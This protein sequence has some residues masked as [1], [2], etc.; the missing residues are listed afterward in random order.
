MLG[1]QATFTESSTASPASRLGDQKSHNQCKTRGLIP[2][3]HFETET[4]CHR[5][6]IAAYAKGLCTIYWRLNSYT[7]EEELISGLPFSCWCFVFR[8]FILN[9]TVLDKHVL[10]SCHHRVIWK[11]AWLIFLLLV[12]YIMSS[13][14]SLS[15]CKYRKHYVI[16]HTHT[17]THTHGEERGH[18][19]P[20]ED[21]ESL[22]WMTPELVSLSS[23]LDLSQA[24]FKSY[25]T[26]LCFQHWI[27]HCILD[28]IELL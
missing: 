18:I 19:P 14:R 7:K 15:Y 3:W 1:S 21:A 16:S 10:S 6:T 24:T 9:Q 4:P 27:R 23:W 8:E 22:E 17:H 28:T 12:S 20:S 25:S 2:H 11:E 13:G 5:N 26:L